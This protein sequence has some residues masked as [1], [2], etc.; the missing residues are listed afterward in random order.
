VDLFASIGRP[1]ASG[2]K[3]GANIQPES[4]SCVF[5]GTPV[6]LFGDA[7]DKGEN[8]IELGWN[9]G[10]L[11]LPVKFGECDIADT[12]WLLQGSRL[13]TDWE[14]RYP[15]AEA[16]AP[17]EKRKQSRVAARL[18]ALSQ[19]YGLA[20]REMSLIAVVTRPGDRPGELPGTHVVPVGMAQDTAFDSYFANCT[21]TS[22]FSAVSPAAAPFPASASM[23]EAA[24]FRAD[25]STLAAPFSEAAAAPPARRRWSLFSKGESADRRDAVPPVKTA[26]DILL[27]LAS[28]MEPDG[29]MPG[30]NRE[31]R[32]SATIVALLAFLSQGHTPARGAFRSHV[33][34]L[35]SFLQSLTGLS[36]H[37]QQVVSAV[38]QLARKG[39]APV[40]DWI[41]LAR[42]PGNHLNEVERRLNALG[43][44]L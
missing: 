15:S 23:T 21:F 43:W 38:I 31:S 6:L 10:R 1:V 40:G 30:N 24:L 14:S 36:S 18:L 28:G 33:A 34:R 29:G 5:S 25:L 35:E 16:L 12:L 39:T 32:V 41:T 7:G 17:L 37:L 20:S 27:D 3:A 26:E 19:T 9:G 2:L 22:A 44:L 4:P 8:Q 11:N 42:T 13:I